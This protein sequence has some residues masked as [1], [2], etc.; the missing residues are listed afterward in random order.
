MTEFEYSEDG[1]KII[2]KNYRN[3]VV[4]IPVAFLDELFGYK[5]RVGNLDEVSMFRNMS[6]PSAPENQVSIVSV[7]ISELVG[8][9]LIGATC[10]IYFSNWEDSEWL[11]TAE[12]VTVI[13]DTTYGDSYPRYRFKFTDELEEAYAK[14]NQ[15]DEDD[16]DIDDEDSSIV[17]PRLMY[18]SWEDYNIVRVV[19]ETKSES[20]QQ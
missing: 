3:E 19:R 11:S 16:D 4:E 18:S 6:R 8:V 20:V 5:R 7:P 2:W 14:E 15:Y 9:D 12:A 1:T 13:E 10:S 17:L